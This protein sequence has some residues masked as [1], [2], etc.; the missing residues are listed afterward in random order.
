VVTAEGIDDDGESVSDSDDA[1]VQVINV[2]S[3]IEVT[4]TADPAS[5]P[6]PGADVAYSV[7]VENT[8]A[9]DEV[10]IYSIVD[11]Q[12]GD[13]SGSC[14]RTLPATLVTG[15]SM[16]CGFSAYIGGE[17]GDSHTNLVT[18]E[19]I[20]DD[21]ESVS[22]SDDAL[23][24]VIDVPSV[25]EVIKTASPY[26]MYYP[27]GNVV[28]R[29]TVTNQ[30][31]VD[32]VTINK[33]VDSVY[34]DLN[35]RGDCTV[36]QHLVIGGSYACSFEAVVM[37]EPDSTH[38]NVVT[39]SGIDSD[40]QAVSDWDSAT[41]T[42]S[43]LPTTIEL[44]YFRATAGEGQIAVEWETIWEQNNWGFNLY[45]GTTPSFEEAAWLHFTQAQGSGQFQGRP[46]RY[47]DT[48][49]IPGQEYYYWLEDVGMAG[50]ATQYGPVTAAFLH[51]VFVPLVSR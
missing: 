51:R 10:T 26:W 41:V 4:K 2:P 37:G 14:S 33:L 23:V 30:S 35:V 16:S 3:T 11:N 7:V 19:G 47:E 49:I 48:E 31:A 43:Q 27:G 39:A 29:V 12:F 15:A 38:T 8:S 45:R 5:V 32:T 1:V 13:I 24:E 18:A 44:L 9:V 20:D 28:F 6:E 42:I 36:P 34:G 40:G 17:P 25:I 21:G 22:D 50:D 46:Y